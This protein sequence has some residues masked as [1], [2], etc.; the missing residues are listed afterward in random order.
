MPGSELRLLNS[1]HHF[2]VTACPLADIDVW[3]YY[4]NPANIALD[5]HLPFLLDKTD[6]MSLNK[7]NYLTAGYL[8]ALI[9]K[10]LSYYILS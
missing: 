7:I 1:S 6:I 4:D 2:L 10:S 8:C 5:S 3:D 9:S